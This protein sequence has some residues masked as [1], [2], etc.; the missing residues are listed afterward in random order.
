[1]RRRQMG[2]YLFFE[3]HSLF[4]CQKRHVDSLYTE[5]LQLDLRTAP[6]AYKCLFTSLTTRYP[7]WFPC[8][9]SV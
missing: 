7:S 4:S 8:S 1:M 9:D 5:G 6:R 3:F 2:E